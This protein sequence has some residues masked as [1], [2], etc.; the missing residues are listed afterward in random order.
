MTGR[1][2]AGLL[3]FLGK[4]S[5]PV[6]RICQVSQAGVPAPRSPGR[7]VCGGL[8]GPDL[9]FCPVPLLGRRVGGL[10]FTAPRCLLQRGFTP[11]AGGAP[12]S[13]KHT[14]LRPLS[15]PDWRPGCL[16]GGP[17]AQRRWQRG[18]LDPFAHR[19]DRAAS[20]LAPP[21]PR[22]LKVGEET[23]AGPLSS[24]AKPLS[25]GPETRCRRQHGPETS[26]S[27]L[28]RGQRAL[29]DSPKSSLWETVPP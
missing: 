17:G 4:K 22:N 23:P 9:P 7:P 1:P 26:S 6:L 24:A 27:G 10:G 19:G 12:V 21:A 2:L 11:G 20:H 15:C 18:S 28:R 13:E 5:W 29:S 25:P 16:L 14:L 8:P 3:C